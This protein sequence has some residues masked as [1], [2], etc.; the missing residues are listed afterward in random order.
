M[1]VTR[2][3]PTSLCEGLQIALVWESGPRVCKN[4]VKLQWERTEFSYNIQK[5]QHGRKIWGRVPLTDI[6]YLFTLEK[7]GWWAWPLSIEL[8]THTTPLCAWFKRLEE[9]FP[10]VP[11]VSSLLTVSNLR[12][13][14]PALYIFTWN[15]PFLHTNKNKKIKKVL[16]KSQTWKNKKPSWLLQDD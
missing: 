6:G 7:P 5:Q 15:L 11:L 16:S 8:C 4:L 9:Y 2:A 12:Q 1:K 13:Q 10:H 3:L 14:W